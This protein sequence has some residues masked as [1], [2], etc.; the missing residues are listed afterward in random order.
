MMIVMELFATDQDAEGNDVGGCIGA[1]IVAI[2]P[3]VT[4]TVDDAGRCYWNPDHLHGP[5]GNTDHAKQDEVDHEQDDHAQPAVL[6]VQIALDPVAWRAMT[7]FRH[8]FHVFRFGT[9]QLGAFPEDFLDA[10]RNR[11]MRIFFR[12]ALGVMLAVNRSP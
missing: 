9:V 7:V 10:A 3:I 1:V 4:D 12:I 6:G 11:A 5:Y 2:T 8:G